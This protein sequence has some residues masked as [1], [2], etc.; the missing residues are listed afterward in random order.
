MT[1][2]VGQV[3]AAQAQ[4]RPDERL[5]NIVFMGMG[6]PL[7]NY[8]A[9]VQAIEILT[10]EWGIGFSSRRITVSTVGL[11]PAMQRLVGDTHVNLAVSLSGHD[12]CAAR[13][14][15]ADQSALSAGDT[16]GD[17][18]AVADSAAPPHHVRVRDAGR[19]Q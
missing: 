19:R 16:H 3:L 14:A 15:H 5:T 8:D 11:V 4:L 10:A 13:A 1:E 17:V 6:E 12:R 7:A 2:I 9:V 18:P